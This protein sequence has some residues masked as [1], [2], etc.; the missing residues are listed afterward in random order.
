[1]KRRSCSK[2]KV[3]EVSE[4]HEAESCAVVWFHQRPVKVL[5]FE[6]PDSG[7]D[8]EEGN[9]ASKP[10]RIHREIEGVN[11]MRKG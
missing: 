4:E 10:F 2:R 11:A 3:L 1:V 8:L 6:R 7:Q 5:D 9:E